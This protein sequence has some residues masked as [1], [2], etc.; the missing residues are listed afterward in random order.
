[1]QPNLIIVY[2]YS[3]SIALLNI[4]GNEGVWDVRKTPSIFKKEDETYI[5]LSTSD[6]LHNSR[7]TLLKST[8]HW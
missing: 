5:F 6:I 4:G 8:K 7:W 2:I 3:M 1:M